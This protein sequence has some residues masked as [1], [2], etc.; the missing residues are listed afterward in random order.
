MHWWIHQEI[1]F[2]VSLSHPFTLE[3]PYVC[4]WVSL[5]VYSISMHLLRN[6]HLV[7]FV[8][9]FVLL[10]L[11]C[12]FHFVMSLKLFLFLH[13]L[14]H[15]VLLYILLLLSCCL[16][17]HFQLVTSFMLFLSC[18]FYNIFVLLFFLHSF[19]LVTS[20]M[21]FS[22]ITYFNSFLSLHLL[23]CLC[24]ASSFMLFFLSCTLYILCTLISSTLHFHAQIIC[25]DCLTFSHWVVM[26]HAD[27]FGLV[28]SKLVSQSVP[29]KCSIRSTV[30][31]H[32]G[33]DPVTQRSQ[34]WSAQQPCPH[35]KSWVSPKVLSKTEV[36]SLTVNYNE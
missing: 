6:F 7:Y 28:R 3:L 24:L 27:L 35:Q 14:L 12:S 25:S 29:H 17:C 26:S 16:L 22:L 32:C 1:I 2:S 10:H 15:F 4:G 19:C 13:H 21:S 20:F 9:V 23:W 36:P 18:V 34:V 11:S 33:L 30:C 5:S 8:H 31:H